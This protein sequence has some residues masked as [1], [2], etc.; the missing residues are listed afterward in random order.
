[1]DTKWILFDD[2]GRLRSGWRFAVFFIGFIFAAAI[3]GG[4]GVAVIYSL[5]VPFEPGTPTFLMA[6]G[7]L[8]L[9]PALLVGWLC[10]KYLESLP[11][12]ALGAW[13][14]KGW[15][16]NL[17]AGIV[18]GAGTLS[19]AVL[20]AYV[21]GGLRFEWAGVDPAALTRSLAISF[22]IFAVAAASEEALFRGY[23]LQ[24]LNRSG[25]AWIGIGITSL[26]FGVV[27]MQNPGANIISTLDTVIA[28]VWF[29]IA[30]LKTRDLWF[31]WGMHLI[32][33][34]MQGA[35]FG[36]EVSGMT[37]FVSASVLREVDLGPAWLTGGS[38]GIEGGIAS[39]ISLVVSTAAIYYL[40]LLRPS[41]EMR[42]MTSGQWGE[43]SDETPLLV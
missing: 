37:D 40:P 20:I 11:F 31:V 42:A 35:V 21:S 4:V 34:W 15:F 22:L 16:R 8:M 17:A 5:G 6:N 27:H 41:E 32:W 7:V 39:T 12:R 30:Y 3:I 10:G 36:I 18:V 9:I 26:F 28:G 33:N 29:G 13:F 19:L 24:T 2:R 38:Y 25:L 23:I 43:A 14:T 1:M